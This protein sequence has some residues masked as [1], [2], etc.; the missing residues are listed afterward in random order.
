MTAAADRPRTDPSSDALSIGS[1]LVS[2]I[3][4]QEA[5]EPGYYPPLHHVAC[6]S[7]WPS[8]RSAPRQ[9]FV[10]TYIHAKPARVHYCNPGRHSS[11]SSGTRPAQ[12][13]LAIRLE[14][15][16]SLPSPVKHQS[17][18][19]EMPFQAGDWIPVESLRARGRSP[20]RPG[21]VAESGYATQVSPPIGSPPVPPSETLQA[22][23]LAPSHI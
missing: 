14:A 9:V 17:L 5:R 18:R 6:P 11:P 20:S 23:T 21:G 4:Y 10:C 12:A 2:S 22:V 15:L 3:G 19:R 13:I 16:L 1:V 7:P 8:V